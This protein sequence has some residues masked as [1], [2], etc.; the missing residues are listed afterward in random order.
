MRQ[1]LSQRLALVDG[2]DLYAILG[3]PRDAKKEQIKAAYLQAAKTFHP[4]RFT[5]P[6][7]EGMRPQVGTL[8]SKINEAHSILIDDAKREAYDQ[9]Q[10]GPQ[11]SAEDQAKAI[12][13][14]NAEMSFREGEICLKRRDF[15]GAVKAFARAVE[16]AP[17]EGEHLALLAWARVCAK[18]TALRDI[19]KD[20]ERALELTPTSARA[21]YYLGV[22]LRDEGDLDRAVA[23]LKKAVELDSKLTDAFAELRVLQSRREKG[24]G[25]K[26]SSGKPGFFEMPSWL[27]KK[28]KK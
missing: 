17:K 8:F 3:V 22:L 6:G 4:D 10:S 20:L 13:A 12:A 18:E 25:S 16:L 15:A 11:M 23:K 28:D 7:M 9:K 2:G 1:Q 19:R 24:G 14:I 26:S 5:Q 27:K 21:H